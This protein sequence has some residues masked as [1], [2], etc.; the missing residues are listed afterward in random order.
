MRSIVSTAE[1]GL[2]AISLALPAYHV[3]GVQVLVGFPG[4]RD[5]RAGDNQ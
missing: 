2:R 3:A 4:D 1:S 5:K